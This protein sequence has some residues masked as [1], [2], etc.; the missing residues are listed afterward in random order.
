MDGIKIYTINYKKMIKIGMPGWN[1][2]Q[3]QARTYYS[4]IEKDDKNYS[5]EI[6]DKKLIKEMFLLTKIKE[7]LRN[8][9]VSDDR[10]LLS[11][12]YIEDDNYCLTIYYH[13]ADSRARHKTISCYARNES[14]YKIAKNIVDWVNK[15]C[16]E[17]CLL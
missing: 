10:V 8:L 16:E 9:D 2:H 15:K 4:S 5:V 17:R 7:E 11:I 6:S 12:K 1:P 14:D 3:E 13:P